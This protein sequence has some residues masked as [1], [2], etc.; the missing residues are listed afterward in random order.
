MILR[1]LSRKFELCGQWLRLKFFL[2][3]HVDL[4]N[5]P[6]GGEFFRRRSSPIRR[7]S[8]FFPR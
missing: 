7:I 8:E 6:G 4:F 5:R 1:C 3:V 2:H